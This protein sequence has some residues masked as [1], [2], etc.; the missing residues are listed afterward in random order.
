[1]P[2]I[3]DYERKYMGGD[4]IVANVR[5]VSRLPLIATV[6]AAVAGVF[7]LISAALTGQ[8]H[9]AQMIVGALFAVG[10]VVA[11]F[12]LGVLMTV[13]R[14]TVT[15]DAIYAQ[16]GPQSVRVPIASI[17]SI[18]YRAPHVEFPSPRNYYFLRR[19]QDG[20]VLVVEFDDEHGTHRKLVIGMDGAEALLRAVEKF[21]GRG[22]ATSGV[23]VAAAA[24]E[25]PI[26]PAIEKE[27]EAVLAGDTSEKERAG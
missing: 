18:E 3:D 17:T 25:A 5:S 7:G 26:D 19:T 13:Q 2:Q 14:A 10:A 4:A 16:K 1:M 24:A 12:T 21:R 27:V 23:R 9:A 11:Y 8:A 22:A 6:F 20:K 15:P